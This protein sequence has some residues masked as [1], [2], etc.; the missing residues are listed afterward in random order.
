MATSAASLVTPSVP[1]TLLIRFDR[2]YGQV[3]CYPA[4]KPAELLARIAGTKTLKSDTVKA[5]R[6]LGMDVC[7]VPGSL[8]TLEDFEAG[9][10]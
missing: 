5:A 3:K 2:I 6:A 1:P 9:R 4:N 7:L 8:A 10:I